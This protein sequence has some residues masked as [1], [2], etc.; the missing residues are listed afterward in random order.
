MAWNAVFSTGVWPLLLTILLMASLL[1]YSWRRRSVPGAR[2]FAVAAL[3]GTL[4]IIGYL[5]QVLAVDPEAKVFW[6]KFQASLQLPSVTAI[7]CFVLEFAWPGRWLTRRNLALLSIAPL[8]DITLILTKDAFNLPWRDFSPAQSVITFPGPAAWIT[9]G[10]VYF[11]VILN[12]IVFAWLFLHVP[13]SRWPVAIMATGQ[14]LARAI[15]MLSFI[16][17]IHTEVPVEILW[18][19]FV[20]LI[21][22]VV[23]FGFHIFD[24]TPLARRTAIEQLQ[25]GIIVLD[26]QGRVVSLNPA[27]EK[28]LMAPA[29]Q[30]KGRP[31]SEL[32]PVDL[33]GFAAGV[34]AG[35]SP[36]S[37][38]T[39]LEFSLE[40]ANQ[41]RQYSMRVTPF[42]DFRGLDTGRLLLL[43]DVSEQ[44]RAQAQIV[45]QQRALAM[46][47]EREQLARELHDSIGQVLGYVGF[48][49]DA[50]NQ[51]IE[52]R[53]LET[54]S[55]Q[56]QRLGNVVREAHA[57][58]R[59]VI[60]E[61]HASPSIHKDF[62]TSL[63]EYLEGF[64][65]NYGIQTRLAVDSHFCQE[66][67]PE[68]A[69]TQVFRILQEAMSNAR[70]HGKARSVEVTFALQGSCMVITVQDDGAG[71]DLS[72]PAADGH[73]GL[74]FMHERAVAIG[75]IL[76]VDSNR[77]SG[78][79]VVL[80]IPENLSRFR[81]DAM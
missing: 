61:L 37:S 67:L 39:P 41:V 13:Q 32:L 77:G 6:L 38:E 16:R 4:Y 31:V 81:N 64:T 78:T 10:Y 9:L 36:G 74:K 27:A 33:P 11:L 52:N 45:E 49:V 17:V 21:Y 50:A 56:L 48:Q 71:F 63:G 75:G 12:L 26:F 2:P 53:Q 62:F 28:M 20:F 14:I 54:A 68:A 29:R 51:L 46:L 22:F 60:L 40:R 1:I 3:F 8:V 19:G 23:L 80:Q 79:Q 47:N 69:Q 76:S 15:Y 73:F 59:E 55:A 44:K 42:K 18:L 35:A 70:K 30:V 57:D 66:L 58:L 24:P 7:S 5:F 43:E 34:A 25:A 72:E 65:N